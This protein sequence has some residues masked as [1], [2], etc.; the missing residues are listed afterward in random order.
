VAEK[1]TV[2]GLQPLP[3]FALGVAVSY[4]LFVRDMS[5]MGDRLDAI[6]QQLTPAVP[7]QNAK[8]AEGKAAKEHR[9]Q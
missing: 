6:R 5:Q 4:Y 1:S 9:R 2:K 7:A 8:P 3:G